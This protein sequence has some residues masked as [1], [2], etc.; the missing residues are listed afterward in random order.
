MRIEKGGGGRLAGWTRTPSR[1]RSLPGRARVLPALL[2]L[3]P[4]GFA[5]AQTES[6]GG[7]EP[8]AAVKIRPELL[9]GKTYRFVT[10]TEMRTRLPDL[11]T[12]EMTVEQQ[13]RLD[14]G[15]RLDGRKGVAVKARTERLEVNL[16]SAERALSYD[17]LEPKD[18]DT[19]LGRHFQR[20]LNRSLDLKLDEDLRIVSTE[21]GGR[22]GME[23]PMPDLP[24]FGPDELRQLVASIPQGLP[25]GRVKV[26]DDW[27]LE[28]SRAVGE[29]G[30]VSFEVTYR[31]LGYVDFEGYR[32][33]E[34]G[35]DGRLNGDMALP[36]GPDSAF[37]RGRMDFRGPG[38]EGR[39]LFDPLEGMVR[40]SEQNI[41]MTLEVPRGSG[42]SPVE[43]PMEQRATVRLLHIVPSG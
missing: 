3:A 20:S 24:R 4:A 17:S 23:D 40:F 42:E 7:E 5:S 41:R 10:R 32:C 43:I 12:K 31:F 27:I 21:E 14:V 8:A 19:T 11:G 1:G 36:G 18:K 9:P 28:G 37:S 33:A 2:L 16:R 22:A 39:M 38:L 29:A 13:A 35:I 26:G 25:E 34:I 30:E 15:I 6:P